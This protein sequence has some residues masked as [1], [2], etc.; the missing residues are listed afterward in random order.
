MSSNSSRQELLDSRPQGLDL[1]PTGRGGDRFFSGL[2]RGSG[3]VVIALVVFVAAFLLWLAVPALRDNQ[4]SF[5]FSRTWQPGLT[6][7]K[8]GI[9]DLLW[10]TVLVSALALLLAVPVALGVALF[11]THYAPARLARPITYVVDLL[12]AVP[13]IIFGLWGITELAP[14]LAPVGNFLSAHNL[15]IPFLK[16][17]IPDTGTVFVAGVVLA[18]MILPIIAAF[19]REVFAQTPAEHREA[20]LALGATK[21]E[22]IRMTVLPYGRSGMVS[23]AMLGLGRALG[24]TIAIMIILSTPSPGAP[25]SASLFAGG[26]TF[27]S[28]IANNAAEFDSPSKTGAYIAAGLVLFVLTFAVNALARLVLLHTGRKHT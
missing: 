10:T 8:F 12:A 27:A 7:P 5:L 3:L 2:A 13:S 14:R 25:F 4:A 19:T 11:L 23:A 15:G 1:G 16:P 18:I 28:K 20:A 21:W 9:V 26:E 6:P 24:E 22:M 17:G